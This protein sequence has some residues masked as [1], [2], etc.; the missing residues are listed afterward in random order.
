MKE[1]HMKGF[2]CYVIIMTKSWNIKHREMGIPEEI[3]VLDKILLD[4]DAM[5]TMT[6]L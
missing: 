2:F 5:L 6:M 1:A 3:I 4:I